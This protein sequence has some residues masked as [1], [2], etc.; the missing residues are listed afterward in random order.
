MLIF[1]QTP[2]LSLFSLIFFLISSSLIIFYFKPIIKKLGESLRKR[3]GEL[4]NKSINIFLS[5]KL[6]KLFRKELFFE[7]DIKKIL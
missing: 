7:E 3:D 4:I 1:I 6:I 5:I 2:S